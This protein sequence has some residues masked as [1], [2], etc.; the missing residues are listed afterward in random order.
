MEPEANLTGTPLTAPETLATP[1]PTLEVVLCSDV[2]TQLALSALF[3]HLGF[4]PFRPEGDFDIHYVA[5]LLLTDTLLLVG[6]ILLLLRSHGERAAD[7]FFGR[8]PWLPEL[9]AAIFMVFGA[10]AI[11]IAVMVGVSLLA[12]W[13]HT[14][15]RNPL[16]GLL[17]VPDDAALFAIVVVIA[18]GI[19]EEVQRAFVLRRFERWLGGPAVGVIVSSVAFGSGHLVQGADAAV[20]TGLL[21]AYW[22]VS[23]LRR[24]SIVAP[25]VSHAIFNVLQIAVFFARNTTA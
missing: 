17:Q 6:L 15:E 8:R 14:V 18:G 21:G 9:R 1:R 5:P 2:P 4:R 22:G 12:P 19:R 16:E 11:A 24:R 20:A 23:Y 13:L 25:V 3:L 10:F 7:V